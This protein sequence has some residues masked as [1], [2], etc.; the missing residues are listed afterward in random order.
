MFLLLQAEAFGFFADAY[1]NRGILKA[2]KLNDKTGG[3]ADLEKVKQLYFAQGNMPMY[4]QAI[5]TK[6]KINDLFA[7]RGE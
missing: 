7:K 6:N 4:Q 5:E 2:I 3:F 1:N